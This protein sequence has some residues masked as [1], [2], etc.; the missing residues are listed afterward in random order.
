MDR[1]PSPCNTD[2]KSEGA[3]TQW[4]ALKSLKSIALTMTLKP[5]RKKHHPRQ[6]EMKE[7]KRGKKLSIK[8]VSSKIKETNSFYSSGK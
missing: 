7:R 8:N 2:D 5:C 3:F 1:V 6:R 4:V